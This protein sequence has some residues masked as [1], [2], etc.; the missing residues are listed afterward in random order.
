MAGLGWSNP[1]PAEI[2]GGTSSVEDVYR[3]LRSVVG[4]GGAGPEDSLEDLWRQSRALG[5]ALAFASDDRAGLQ[6]FPSKATDALQYYEE[7]LMVPLEPGLENHERQELVSNRFTAPPAASEPDLAAG[8]LAI[9]TRISVETV[10]LD[11][12]ETTYQGRVFE[13]LAASEPFNGGRKSTAFGNY[14]TAFILT[15]LV[16]IGD[17]ITPTLAEEKILQRAAD[18]LNEALPGWVTFNLVTSVGFTLDVDLLDITA[19]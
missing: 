12:S 9:D 18:Y 2:G 15:I 6:F 4:I 11:A 14:A 8:L 1:L 16:N 19:L 13:D 10:S 7:L 3:S 17:G 5:I